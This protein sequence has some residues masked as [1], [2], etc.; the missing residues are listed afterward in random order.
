MVNEKEHPRFCEVEPGSN[1]LYPEDLV[2]PTP[3]ARWRGGTGYVVDTGQ[4]WEERLL[5][6]QWR[7]LQPS[8]KR[9]PHPIEARSVLAWI[10]ELERKLAEEEEPTK[11][12][13]LVAQGVDGEPD[14]EE[15]DGEDEDELD[16]DGDPEDEE[17]GDAEEAEKEGAE[18]G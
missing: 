11:E 7:K 4:P 9:K 6:G 12:E 13:E 8:K 10:R 2:P 1:L 16:T 5:D 17:E 18:T 15:G 14:H 3:G